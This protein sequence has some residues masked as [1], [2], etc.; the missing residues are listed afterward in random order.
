MGFGISTP[1]HVRQ[2]TQWANGAVVGS[3]LVNAIAKAGGPA[4]EIA[5]LV[6]AL[7]AGTRR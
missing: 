3:A 1:E 5:G 2:V 4:P 7:K 6:R